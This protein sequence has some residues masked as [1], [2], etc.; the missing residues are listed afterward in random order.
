MEI[1]SSGEK[2]VLKDMIIREDPR[3]DLALQKTEQGDFSALKQVLDE[4]KSAPR[5][6]SLDLVADLGLDQLD[7]NF[8]NMDNFGSPA[9]GSLEGGGMSQRAEN[10]Q[11]KLASV[12]DGDLGAQFQFDDDTFDFMGDLGGS[13]ELPQGFWGFPVF[14]GVK[15]I[16]PSVK[17]PLSLPHVR[18]LSLIFSFPLLESHVGCWHPM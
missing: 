12:S 17:P 18:K 14:H 3:L 9:T 16:P 4:A 8:L 5:R 7:L 11:G 1:I 2:G 10:S 6:S 13:G 15:C